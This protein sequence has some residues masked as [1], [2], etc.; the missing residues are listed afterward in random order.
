[1]HA[2][3]RL[4]RFFSACN[5][6]ASAV[7]PLE[8]MRLEKHACKAVQIGQSAP[9]LAQ[10]RFTELNRIIGKTGML[11]NRYFPLKSLN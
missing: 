8:L 9:G 3:N 11:K 1:V 10:R 6:S 4:G 2:S 7:Q 5:P